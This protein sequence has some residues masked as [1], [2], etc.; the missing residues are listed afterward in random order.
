[1][2]DLARRVRWALML[3]MIPTAAGCV[4]A[5]A[6]AAA[7]AAGAIAYTN[8]GVESQV[9]A[10]VP[11]TAS[12]TRQVFSDLGISLTRREV[13]RE[14]DEIELEGER[15]DMDVTVTIEEGDDGLTEVGVIAKTSAVEYDRDYARAVLRRIVARVS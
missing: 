5:A 10:S 6:G 4:A 12:A 14:D 13:D 7:G 2:N 3:T 8:R 9:D 1:M 15:G 11:A